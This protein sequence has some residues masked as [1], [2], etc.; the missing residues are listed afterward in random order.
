MR[1]LYAIK[2]AIQKWQSILV[3]EDFLV[4]SDHKSL[5]FLQNTSTNELSIRLFNILFY[6]GHFKFRIL[7]IPGRDPRMLTSDLLS[8]AGYFESGT[9]Q[10]EESDS[11]EDP[12]HVFEKYVNN[13]EV[14]N[15]VDLKKIAENQKS[16][17]F[18]KKKSQ[19]KFF[20]IKDGILFKIL[21]SGKSL[22]VLTKSDAQEISSFCHCKKGHLGANRLYNFLKDTFYAENFQDI[23]QQIT[24]ECA[25]CI[26]VKF[27]SK[28]KGVTK[29]ILDVEVKPFSKVYFDLIDLGA[30]SDNEFRYGVSY[31]CSLTKFLDIE[32]IKSKTNE[33]VCAALLKL[34]LRYGLPECA[35]TDNGKEVIGKTNKTLY[36]IY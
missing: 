17:E 5:E 10:L 29:E 21:K 3:A 15:I 28:S 1:E 20:Q 33:N 25:D 26:S 34:F 13:T 14:S 32:P 30:P 36:K 23:C 24:N 12:T 19:T 9:S 8:R 35:V 7:H 27:K 22:I 2:Y 16:D 18:C 31:M 4:L 6:L 11:F